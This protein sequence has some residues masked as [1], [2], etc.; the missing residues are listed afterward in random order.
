M[1]LENAIRVAASGLTA[2]S[3]RLRVIAENLANA[4][5][6]GTTPGAEPYRRQVI[7]FR[8]VLDRT[9]GVKEVKPGTVQAAGGDFQRKY[10]PTHPAADAQGYVLMPNVNP[11]IEM[12]DMREAQQSYAA[13]LNVIDAAKSMISR[14]ID[15]LHG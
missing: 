2:E 8:S 9:Y 6:T 14:A 5:S 3:A 10:D 12:M 4:D 1:E 7:T 13:N 15:L 11:L